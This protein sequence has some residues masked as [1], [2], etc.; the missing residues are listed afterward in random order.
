MVDFATLIEII[1]N[2]TRLHLLEL[3]TERPRGIKELASILGVTPQ[4]V[5][6]HLTVLER[7]DII[8]QIWIDSKSKIRCVYSINRPFYLGYTFKDGVLCLYI[9][10]AQHDANVSVDIDDLRKITYK[11]NLLRMRTKVIANRLRALVAEDLTMQTEIHSAMKNLKLSP[12]Q[13]IALRCFLSIDSRKNMLEGSR[14]TGL[15]LRDS[16]RHIIKSEG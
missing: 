15:N 2:E 7:N 1:G 5:L 3:L 11:R 8:Q 16:I 6:K 14:E 9:G 12:V 10:S 13:N 4:A